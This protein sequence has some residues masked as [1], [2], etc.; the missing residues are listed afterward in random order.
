MRAPPDQ[1]NTPMTAAPALDDGP[2]G[3]RRGRVRRAIVAFATV[4]SVALF[5]AAGHWQRDRMHAKEEA[6]P[7]AL[8]C[9]CRGPTT[10]RTG[11]TGA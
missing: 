5:V 9:R 1:S 3:E 10:G 8:R 11:A 4:A 6:R 7:R 2:A